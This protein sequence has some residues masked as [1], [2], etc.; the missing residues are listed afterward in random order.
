MEKKES[1]SRGLKASLIHQRGIKPLSTSIEVF[2]EIQTEWWQQQ[3]DVI[4]IPQHLNTTYVRNV[5]PAKKWHKNCCYKSK[6]ILEYMVE[7]VKLTP[8]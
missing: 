5:N 8:G 7:L 6:A 3:T 4:I 1:L 2:E